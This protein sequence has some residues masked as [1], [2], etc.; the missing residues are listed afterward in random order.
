MILS[1][2]SLSVLEA[3][4]FITSD[5]LKDWTDQIKIELTVSLLISGAANGSAWVNVNSHQKFSKWVASTLVLNAI[6]KIKMALLSFLFQFLSG[7]IGLKSV[8]QN[9]VK[10]F[11]AISN[12]V[13][14]TT[15]KIAWSSGVVSVS[16]LPLS[17][18]LYNVL[19]DIFSNNIKAALGIFGVVTSVKLKSTDLWQYVVVHFKDTSSAAAAFTHWSVLVRKDSIRILLVVNQNNVISLR[20]A[21]KAK[22]VNLPFG[23][24]AFEIIEPIGFL[25]V[26]ITKLLSIPPVIDVLVKKSLAE[27]AKQIK[28]VNAVTSI[29][30]K[31]IM[32]LKKKCEQACLEKVFDND[33]INNDNNDDNKDF[34]V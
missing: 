25:V 5:D 15:F 24:T 30:Q 16:F 27:L 9:A 8:L 22:L 26:L 33:D 13:F 19:L 23:Y 3:K 2:R 6:F 12:K 4:Q 18:A 7:C 29:M 21:F 28:A 10:F 1:D 34:L 11:L 14:L 17:V 20:D 31:K 32:N